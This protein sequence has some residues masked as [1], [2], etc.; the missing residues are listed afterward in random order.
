[1]WHNDC[2]AVDRQQFTGPRPCPVDHRP[3]VET[4]A[5]TL[6]HTDGAA[7]GVNCHADGA[8]DASQTAQSVSL[9]EQCLCMLV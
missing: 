5:L 8:Q 9:F 1:M 7:V 2:V 4:V 6:A 3:D